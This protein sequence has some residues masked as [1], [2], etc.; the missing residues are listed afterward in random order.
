[1]KNYILSLIIII[2]FAVQA[3][4]KE[5]FKEKERAI[6]KERIVKSISFNTTFVG[7]VEEVIKLVNKN[8]IFKGKEKR[9]LKEQIDKL[10]FNEEKGESNS[11]DIEITRDAK[12]NELIKRKVVIND[13]VVVLN[14]I[15]N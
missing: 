7:G 3:N 15:K 5:E 4:E 13:I 1:M 12:T 2:S 14:E 9:E 10:Q 6:K 11:L 8:K